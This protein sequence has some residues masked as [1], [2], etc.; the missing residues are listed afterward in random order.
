MV[1]YCCFVALFLLASCTLGEDYKQSDFWSNDEI[2][3][4]L[5]VKNNNSLPSVFWYQIFG[6]ENLNLMVEQALQTAPDIKIVSAKLKQARYAFDIKES[7]YL[8][9]FDIASGY[10]YAYAPN[11]AEFGNKDSYFKLGFDASWELD[12]WGKGRRTKESYL[13]MYYEAIYNL[14]NAKLSLTAEVAVDYVGLRMGQELLKNARENLQLQKEIKNLVKNK[15]D[16]GIA[17]NIA[18]NQAEYAVNTTQSL[19]PQF[20]NQINSY[21]NALFILMGRLPSDIKFFD[22]AKNNLMKN[23]PKFDL[24]VLREIP[25]ANLRCRPDVMAAES[26]L[27]A[28]NAEAGAA[29]ASMFPDVS[30]GAT[31]GRQGHFLKDL[32]H[33]YNAAYGYAPQID[34]PFFHWGQL[35]NELK[36]A[37]AAKEEYLYNYQKVL[38]T[39]LQEVGD[40]I[41][42]V[43]KEY[44]KNN[45]LKKAVDNMQKVMGSMKEK[46]AQGL[47]NFSDLLDTEQSLLQVQGKLIESR[48]AIYEKVIAFYKAIGGGYCRLSLRR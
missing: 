9:M 18:L 44:E 28:K 19:V 22:V 13:A 23:N 38:L 7:D 15:Y 32:R 36:M 29:L 35:Y 42:A 40:A 2:A 37:K 20:E 10:N 21:K 12:I 30:I 11:Y 31:L 39:A 34:L 14:D 27:I 48:G 1:R 4:S 24:R 41:N 26:M 5:R 3:Q 16:A 17:D 6:D 47:I 45:S 33:A 43:E 8:P 25:I 46:Y